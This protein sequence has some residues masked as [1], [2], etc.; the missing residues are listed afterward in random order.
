M[1]PEEIEA[2]LAKCSPTEVSLFHVKNWLRRKKPQ[3]VSFRDVPLDCFTKPE[4]ILIVESI[5]PLFHAG[6]SEVN[7]QDFPRPSKAAK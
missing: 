6:L 5:V 1:K 7:A 3:G 2:F 4:L